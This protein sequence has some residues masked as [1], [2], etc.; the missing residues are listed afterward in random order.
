MNSNTPDGCFLYAIE[1]E[2]PA[3][4]DYKT[5]NSWVVIKKRSLNAVN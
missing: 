4:M 2:N 1:A 3:R 5:S